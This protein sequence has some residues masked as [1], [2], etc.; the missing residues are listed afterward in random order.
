MNENLE[1]LKDIVSKLEKDQLIF[2][3]NVSYDPS[4]GACRAGHGKIY[5]SP[6][7]W[8]ALSGKIKGLET[9][10]GGIFYKEGNDR[11]YGENAVK[12]CFGKSTQEINADIAQR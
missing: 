7:I 12:K 8:A 1:I 5:A 10:T 11:F 9:V 3:Q 6:V 4:E 2:D